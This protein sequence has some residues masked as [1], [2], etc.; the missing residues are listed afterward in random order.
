MDLMEWACKVID[1]ARPGLT[2]QRSSVLYKCNIL[3]P[4]VGPRFA[5][6]DYIT[7][8]FELDDE[9]SEPSPS[10]STQLP[11][12]CPTLLTGGTGL[13]WACYRIAQESG[14][15]VDEVVFKD[16]EG[17][18]HYLFNDIICYNEI[19]CRAM[20]ECIQFIRSL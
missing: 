14:V 9:R 5:I 20:A 1:N 17:A 18:P 16:R 3:Q 11:S 7:P 8:R 12:I 10:L 4:D 15:R 2:V 19:D 6:E 13:S